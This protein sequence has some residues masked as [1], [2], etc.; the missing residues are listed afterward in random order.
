MTSGIY[1]LIKGYWSLWFPHPQTPE[2][3]HLPL[4][5][6]VGDGMRGTL[7]ENSGLGFRV[8]GLGIRV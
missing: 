7:G 1:S 6:V 8:W 5:L 3:P 2:A 4:K